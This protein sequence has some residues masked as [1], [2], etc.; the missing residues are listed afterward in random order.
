MNCDL[1]GARTVRRSRFEDD[2]AE[3]VA[4]QL[5]A[6]AVSIN[7]GSLTSG[8]WDA[9]NS[10]FKLS[11]MGPSRMGSAGLLRY[12]RTQAIIKQTGQAAAIAAYAEGAVAR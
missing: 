7:D 2:L 4:A 8:V 5:E 3:E 9:E 6:G 11:G 12:F 10:S 1:A